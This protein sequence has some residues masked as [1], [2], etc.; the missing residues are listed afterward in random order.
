MGSKLPIK[1]ARREDRGT[2]VCKAD[3]SVGN[4][5]E[6]VQTLEVEYLPEIEVPR[7]RVPQAPFYE[8]YLVNFLYSVVL[9]YDMTISKFK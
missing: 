2:Y 5:H 3:N 4:S 6:R 7:P 8:A 9:I 1:K